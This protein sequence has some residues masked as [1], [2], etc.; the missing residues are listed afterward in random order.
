MSC[1]MWN[2]WDWK[3]FSENL[4]M[5]ET[6]DSDVFVI[7]NVPYTRCNYFF[8]TEEDLLNLFKLLD[9]FCQETN[10]NVKQYA[11]DLKN[12]KDIY[13]IIDEAH[14]YFDS[15]A[16]LIR[17]NNMEH[18]INVLTQCRKRNIRVVA[19][20]QRL[21]SLDVRFRRLA[22]YVEEYRKWK[23]LNFYWVKHKV[24]ENRWDLADIETDNVVRV[25]QDWEYKTMKEDALIYSEFFKPL[26]FGLQL[27]CAFNSAWRRIKKEYYNTYYICGLPDDRA[28]SI[29]LEEFRNALQISSYNDVKRFT[30]KKSIFNKTWS[31]VV[32]KFDEVL[33][34]IKNI[35]SPNNKRLS[36][37]NRSFDV[38]SVNKDNK[39]DLFKRLDQLKK[40]NV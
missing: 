17:W 25:S 40:E 28:T 22:D 32:Y 4:K 15:R 3:T 38:Q 9:D 6:K 19:I 26:T 34:K 21:T 14:R 13:L 10:L 1:V 7:T 37:Q 2:F 27:F 39:I 36:L 23:L 5:Y 35:F 11:E 24:Y 20:T 16:S 29:T 33:T 18:L 12:Q 8:S 31:F 30:D